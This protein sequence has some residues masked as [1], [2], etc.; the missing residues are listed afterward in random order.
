MKSPPVPVQEEKG[1][2]CA[3]E[4]PPCI[5]AMGGSAGGLEAFEEFFTHLPPNTGLVF[6]LVPHLEPT[7][8]GMLPELLGR[9]TQMPVVQVVD[10]MKVRPN[11]VYVIPPNADLS[12]LH[13][14]LQ[15]LEPVAPRGQ[16]MPIDFFFRHLAADQKEKAIGIILSG[17][18]SDGTL[19]L[20]AIKENF[21][22]VMV[23][24]PASAKYDSMPRSAI[25]T[26]MV[27]YVAAA[28]ELPAKL[29][30]YRRAPADRQQHVPAEAEPTAAFEKVLVLL[31]AHTDCDFSC[32]K[33]T[34]IH[35]RLER[36][37]A[38]HQFDR[39]PLY[40][41][42]LQE[43]P[44]EAELLYKEL[45]IGVT[46][47][48]RDPGLFDFLKEEAIP[49]LLRSHS[50]G[51]PVRVWNPG[52]ST[53]EE[54]YSL[55][56]L[57]RECLA[58]LHLQHV[59]SI[60]IF[61]TDLDKDAIDKAR[62]GT[63]SAGIAADVSPERLARFFVHEDEGYRIKKEVRD[64]VVFAPHNL[65]IDPPFTKV[66]ILCCRNLLIYVNAETQRKLLPLMHYA[67]NPGGLLILGTAESIGS[68]ERLFSVVDKKW[69]VFQRREVAE[70]P[71]LDMPAHILPHERRSAV[72]P[73]PPG[74]PDM[75]ITYAAQRA[76]LDSYAPPSVVVNAEGDILYVNGR[77]GK[78][79]EPS[80]GKV[81]N[82]VFAM[83]REG[84]RE[85]LRVALHNATTRKTTVTTHGV[86]VKSNGGFSA[87]NLTVKPLVEPTSPR[88]MLLVV[89][90]DVVASQAEDGRVEKTP[91]VGPAAEPSELEEEL[92][93]TRERLEA[94]TEEMRA[95]Q[96]E[97]RSANEELQSNNEELQS[98]NEELNSSKEELQSINEEMQTV[99]AEL[100]MKIEELSQSN[101]DM[102]NLLNGIE[103]ATIFLNNDLSVKR[104]TPQA[105]R[106]VNLAA[107]DLGRPLGHFTTNLKYDRLVQDAKEVLDTLVP[108]ELQVQTTE[109]H[110]H[111][112]RVLPYRTLDNMISGVVMT[113][114]DITPIKQLEQSVNRQQAELQ[115]S[116]DYAQG[117]IATI[118]E[119]LVV[120]DGELRIVSA[121]S[122][123][124]STFQVTPAATEGQLFYELDQRQWDIPALREL[125]ENILP[126]STRFEDFRVEHD[127]SG[128]GHRVLLLNARRIIAHDH[129]PHLILLA[130]EDITTSTASHPKAP[131]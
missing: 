108:K 82:N 35:R 100:Q 41:R 74:E 13:G 113:F 67:L 101:S 77:T 92:R 25:N 85:E 4:A 51:D 86:R 48:F 76:L 61:S 91:S 75:D 47:F 71:R 102:K 60:Q 27:D 33:R 117:I 40:V 130:M 127:F 58:K 22:M 64:L 37:M 110:W 73:K 53:G 106:I 81:N 129:Q 42:Y 121:S 15:V 56:I 31:R 30:G 12:I 80:S 105:T 107:S 88:V 44:Q 52:C 131:P 39:L 59:P 95:T 89:F 119:P 1:P 98:T 3:A 83:A 122:A 111:N 120:L 9:H 49:Q 21:G 29:I 124:Y 94:A 96:E 65:L 97:L 36:R 114:A 118:R 87:I 109:G 116:R 70:R 126:E 69:K 43:N 7:H 78:Y 24:D 128:I 6:I 123:F 26:G 20:K 50:A 2:S 115:A 103:I 112:L 16:R 57:L 5:V 93:R 68:S 32:Y 84:L 11:H 23:Q 10:G 104:F 19:G 90:E 72:E 66:D 28:Q 63:F 125:L 34:T 8:K 45:L 46:N 14:K 38:V 17:M 55:A 99:N 18:G 79:L 62:R 54:T